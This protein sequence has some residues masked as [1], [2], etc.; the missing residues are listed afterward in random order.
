MVNIEVSLPHNLAK[1]KARKDLQILNLAFEL[2]RL[3]KLDEVKII[4]IVMSVEGVYRNNLKKNT[5]SLWI[6]VEI[7]P[8]VQKAVVLLTCYIVRKSLTMK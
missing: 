6:S 3:W 7:T 8:L 1:D 5:R 4:S 2:K